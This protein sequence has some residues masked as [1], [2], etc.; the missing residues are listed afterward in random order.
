MVEW[1]A[2][3]FLSTL[4]LDTAARVFDCYLRDGEPLLW[5]ASLALL[6]LLAPRLLS[7]ADAPSALTL[8]TR[9]RTCELVTEKALFQA[10]LSDGDRPEISFDRELAELWIDLSQRLP[11]PTAET[12]ERVCYDL[13]RNSVLCDE[14]TPADVPDADATADGAL[15]SGTRGA[16]LRTS[17][18]ADPASPSALRAAREREPRAG[19]FGS[20]FASGRTAPIA[21]DADEADEAESQ[22]AGGWRRRS[23]VAGRRR[24]L[25][26]GNEAVPCSAPFT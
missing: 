12:A 25:G 5:R 1:H 9:A 24:S 4:P 15:L 21:E 19:P 7:C 26:G 23:S 16:R 2:S 22:W 11:I 18:M 17:S 3:L 20:A 8:L 13:W 6:R 10:L 14:H